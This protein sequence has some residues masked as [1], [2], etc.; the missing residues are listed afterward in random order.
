MNI[1]LIL[2]VKWNLTAYWFLQE[3]NKVVKH[4]H[5]EALTINPHNEYKCAIFPP[6][7]NSSHCSQKEHT[8]IGGGKRENCLLFN[9]L[10]SLHF[11]HFALV[12]CCLA[13]VYSKFVAAL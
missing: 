12:R 3:G 4:V 10:N 6:N 5:L 1:H 8:S 7:L 13:T 9:T 2:S 11:Y